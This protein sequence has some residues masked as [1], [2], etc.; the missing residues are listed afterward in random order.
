MFGGPHEYHWA[1]CMAVNVR[2]PLTLV[3]ELAEKNWSQD[4]KNI[5][6][7]LSLCDFINIHT[8]QDVTLYVCY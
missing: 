6:L 3:R 7:H 8:T 2:N 1:D 4:T 5:D